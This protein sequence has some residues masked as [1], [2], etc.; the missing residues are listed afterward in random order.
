MQVTPFS[1][2]KET[3]ILGEMADAKTD[4]GN[5]QDE[6]AAYCSARK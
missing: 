3:L 2:K 6:I 4:A 1:N 5:I